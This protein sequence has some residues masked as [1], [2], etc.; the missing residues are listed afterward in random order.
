M[1]LGWLETGSTRNMV[2]PKSDRDDKGDIDSVTIVCMGD[3]HSRH[4]EIAVP[5]GD[6]LLHSGDFTMFGDISHATAFNEW[7]GTLP[8]RHKIVVAGNHDSGNRETGALLPELRSLLTNA[9]YL[10]DEFVDL[11][12]RGRLLRIYGTPWQPQY[13]G[14]G[15][16]LS[17]AGAEEIWRRTV[18]SQDGHMP[19]VFL[20]HTP[21]FSVLDSEIK[22]KLGI[23]SKALM[24]TISHSQPLLHC[25]GHIHTPGGL[26]VHLDLSSDQKGVSRTPQ[27]SAS[28]SVEKGETLFV[29]D[30]LATNTIAGSAYTMRKNAQPIIVNIRKGLL[31]ESD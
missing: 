7:L 10:M 19:D 9:T 18:T 15:S 22:G 28:V 17:D 23:G 20:T 11:K 24:R 13:P 27:A 3:S 30:A 12:I 25:F 2:D 26:H 8:H 21:P 6:V 29:N 16:Y 1:R 31:R 14:F 4:D 5:H